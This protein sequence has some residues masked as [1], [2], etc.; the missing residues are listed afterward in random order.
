MASRNVKRL[1]H[2]LCVAQRNRCCYCGRVFGKKGTPTAATIEHKKAR[3]DGG[4][5]ARAN[6]AAACFHCN[7]HRGA[8]MNRARQIKAAC[9]S[10]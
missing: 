10:A 6:L 1:R 2:E 8:Q 3:M 9:R 5:N 7:Q 4:T